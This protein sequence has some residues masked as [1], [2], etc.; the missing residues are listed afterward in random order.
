M[1]LKFW[2][3]RGSIPTPLPPDYIRQML[4]TALKSAGQHQLNL[5]DE[6]A[7]ET[8]VA[9]LPPDE[10]M[11]GG[12]TT[13]L[14]IEL[15][16]DLLI[17]DAG[18]GIRG[19]G[20]HLLGETNEWAKK[21]GFYH[22]QGHAHLFFTHTHLD[23]IQGF[24]FFQPLH[25]PGNK[26]DIYHVHPHVPETL[27]R[28]M[29]PEIFPLQFNQIKAAL[30]FH[31]LAEGEA[32]K[33]SEAII[34]NI[35]LE[36]PGKTYAY[37][38]EAD[39]AIAILA[40]DGEY[41]QLDY[42][43]TAKYRH[44]YHHADALIFDAMFSEREAFVKENWDRGH[45]TP[46]TGAD[47]ARDAQV[48]RLFLFHGQPFSTGK[49]AVELLQQTKEYLEKS[50]QGKNEAPEIVIAREGMEINLTNSPPAPALQIQDYF[51]HDIIFMSLFG[52]FGAHET[53]PF[54]ECLSRNLHTYQADT[55]ILRME[56]LSEL[57]IAGIRALVDARKMVMRLALVGITQPIYHVFELA[58]VTDFFAMYD[59][60]ET[61]LQA[62]NSTEQ[63]E[64]LED[65]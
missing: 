58:K 23:H 9:G 41:E 20:Q 45:S 18:S 28:Q 26:V 19:L 31:Q 34:T 3:T 4:V 5:T 57:N 62:L 55:V 64:L 29:E 22:G 65:K 46:L 33:I 16:H 52:K 14:T 49:G 37:R 61:A 38:V 36:H 42:A 13:C 12:N 56:N 8:F 17:F 7:I 32:V 25:V 63:S 10:G 44:F 27:A 11:I 39:H 53:E 15:A 50:L 24:P 40:T 60:L 51:E 48:K 30:E 47:I 59:E 2:G 35:G 54:L 6:Q 1:R 21:F 43:S